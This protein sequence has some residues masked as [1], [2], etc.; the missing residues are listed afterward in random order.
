[1][2]GTADMGPDGAGL[3]CPDSSMVADADDESRK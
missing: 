3:C 2:Q 1:M